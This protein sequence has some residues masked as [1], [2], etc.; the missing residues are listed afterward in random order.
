MCG[1]LH[2]GEGALARLK[3]AIKTAIRAMSGERRCP[4]DL[5]Q[6]APV[7][8]DSGPPR[9]P[10]TGGPRPAEDGDRSVL[11]R[12][13]HLVVKLWRDDKKA[14]VS[15]QL[16]EGVLRFGGKVGAKFVKESLE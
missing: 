13:R 6:S 16:N 10:E 2:S 15:V 4:G 8:E 12:G 11:R 9:G 5:G 1:G 3:E 14:K 7:G